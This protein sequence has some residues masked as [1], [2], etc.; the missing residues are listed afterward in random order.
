[1]EALGSERGSA[2]PASSTNSLDL[3][4][5]SAR[6]DSAYSSFS[7]ASGG[8][9][10]RTPSPEP[11][12]APYLDWDYVRLVWGGPAR[13][14]PAPGL[15]TCQRPPPPEATSWRPSLPEGQG[16]PG[17]L[18]R[19][20]TPLLYAL[21]AE[22]E[23]AAQIP[24]PLSPPASRAAYR[25]RLQ[26]A[27]R[28][29]LRE[30]SFQRKE[31]RM[32][33]PARLRPAAPARPPT[34]H[35]RSASLSHP[36]GEVDQARSRAPTPGTAGQGFLTSQQREWCLS[37]PGQLDRLG[38]RT[39]P[40]RECSSEPRSSSSFMWPK[41]QGLQ[42]GAK[43]E[44]TQRRGTGDPDLGSLEFAEDNKP[45]IRSQ[46]T[47]GKALGHWEV[48]A[49]GC[50]A[51]GPQDSPA[52]GEQVSKTSTVSTRL[53]SLPDD[54]VFLEET[55]Q[56]GMKVHQD[57]CVPKGLPTSVHASNQ[58]YGADLNQRAGQATDIPEYLL[59]HRN[60]EAS[61]TDSCWQGVNSSVGNSRIT[62]SNP[63]ETTS[64]DFATTDPDR[65]LSMDPPAAVENDPLKLLQVDAL[66]PPGSDTPSSPD[67]I[68]LAWSTGKSCSRPSWP[69]QRLKELVQE[70]VRL[71][72]SLSDSLVPYPSPEPPLDVLDGLIPL[73]ELWAA[74]G[75]ACGEA[76]K[77]ASG[78]PE[79]RSC[80]LSSAQLLTTQEETRPENST[81]Y[82]IPDQ[83]G[84]QGIP[85]ANNI[86]QAKKVELAD[87][88][89]KLLQD[90]QAEQEQLRAAAQACA[91]RRT[92]LQSVV[93]Q[94]CTP[95]EVE[96]FSR[97][98]TDLERVLGLLLLLGSRLARVRYA[99]I[100]AGSDGDPDERASLLQRLRLLQRQQED[101]KELKEHVA[102]RER[103]LRELLVK[104]LSVKE[105]WAYRGL[106]VAKAAV[107]AQQRSLDERV[108]LLQDQ[109]DAVRNDLGHCPLLSRQ[110]WPPGPQP[111]DKPP[112]PLP[113]S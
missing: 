24:E 37:E 36:P 25:Q 3:R 2:S 94:S 44:G 113:F 30:T 5:L 101:A 35:P 97:F 11:D 80:L 42:H 31:F 92:A 61:G 112:F 87:L 105:L 55:P 34:N 109:L 73:A 66:E 72:P 78:P 1:M 26:G 111:P 23:A 20:A 29:V 56:V 74:M 17:L 82:A 51:E 59:L 99:L 27:Q 93:S 45:A 52:D 85:E 4:R 54:D 46:S 107:L 21:A 40:S 9:E 104:R 91:R 71:D 10:P 60:P 22:A 89:K 41:P 100:R 28:R 19:R 43:L 103:A 18:N 75:S 90:L 16:A 15:R 39:R 95:Q 69:C 79:P 98:M 58:Q 76:G 38:Q 33:L 57:N 70:L 86:I 108:R 13:P 8:P 53:P 64:G 67:H 6:N 96:R 68:A 83:S 106:L 81:I 50:P 65:L 48:V 14:P 77:G 84:G 32:S 12:S 88:L 47:S 110:A 102:R 7:A 49:V 63:S 62:C